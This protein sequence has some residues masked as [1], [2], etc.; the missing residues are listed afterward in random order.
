MRLDSYR[1]TEQRNSTRDDYC[2]VFMHIPKTAGTTLASALQWNYPPNRTL[3]IDLLGRPLEEFEIVPLQERSRLALLHGH[4]TYGIHR[5]VPRPCR[6]VTI[7]REPIPRVV[8]AYKYVLTRSRHEL[9]ERVVG[10]GIGLEEFIETYWVDK[11][12]SRQTRQLCDRHDGPLDR[13]AFEEAKRNLEGFLVVGLT[14]RFE[15][16]FAL[17]RRAVRLRLP[18][19]VTRNVGQP[20]HVSKRAIELI[21]EKEQFDLELYDFARDLFAKQL[22]RQGS[23]FTLEASI[24]RGIRPISRAAGAGRVQGFLRRLSQARGAWHRARVNPLHKP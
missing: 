4:V 11:R 23:S 14:E 12:M 10:D 21:R 7:V 9:H 5:Y 24:Y 20:L 16:T 22:G 13:D 8:S 1:R 19:Y 18:F 17:L 2:L 15:E 3:H 6:Y